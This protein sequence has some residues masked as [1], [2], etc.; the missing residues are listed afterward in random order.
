MSPFKSSLYWRLLVSFCAVNLLALLFGGFLTQRFIE[1]GTAVE[2]NWASLAQSAN[3]A[4]ENGGSSALI[5]WS[6]QQRRE[7]IE[8]TLYENDEALAPIHMSSWM[9]GS[10]QDWLDEKRDMVLQPWPNIY[11]AVQQVNSSDGHTRQLVAVS[12]THSR[13]RPQTRQTIF[14]ASQA[15]LSLL[16]IG[17]VGWWVARSVARPVEAIRQATRRM[18]SGVLSAR[19][20]SEGQRAN[21]ELAQLARDFDAMAVRIEALVAHERS[22]LQ[23]LSHELRSPLARLHLILDLARRSETPEAAA[24]Y[25]GQAEQEISRLDHMTGEMLALSRLESGIPGENRERIDV[26]ALLQE[27][28]RRADV[29]AHAR[30]IVLSMA[31]SAPAI[32]SGSTLLLERAFDNLI[33]NA[34]KFSPEGG[35]VEL[36]A[37]PIQRHV[38]CTV[39]DHGP[40]VPEAEL[41]SLFRPLFRG[42]NASRAEGHGLGLAIVQRVA[43]AHGGDIEAR[44]A[45]GGG[46]LVALTLPLAPAA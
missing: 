4:Y 39:R 33:A 26:T 36:A 19:V 40:G 43:R 14:L 21:D 27:C 8:A 1:Y 24:R 22:V 15:V 9:R 46:L 3:E 12:R 11:V 29:E 25:F 10:L 45:E 16:F 13:M 37:N 30:R 6:L 42:S 2:I 41:P 18:A 32:V 44:N 20:G 28:M 17:L 5:E 7:G 35:T 38:L 31:S 23:D 34:I